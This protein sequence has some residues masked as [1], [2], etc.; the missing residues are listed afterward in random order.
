VNPKITIAVAS[1]A[2]GLAGCA[3]NRRAIQPDSGNTQITEL[4]MLDS[5]HGW[6][7]S[8]GLAGQRSLLRTDDGGT[9]WQDVTPHGFPHIEEGASFRDAHTAWVSFFNKSDVTA[10]LLRT[11]DGGKSWSLLNQT[12]TPIFNEASSCRFYSSTYGVG[13][14]SDGGAGSAY[15]IFFETRDSGKTW[16]RIPLMPRH[17]ESVNDPS[18]F[19]LSN[20]GGDRIAFC[21]PSTVIITFGDTADEQPK[22]VARLSMTTNLGKDWRDVELPLPI[23]FHNSLCVPLKPVFADKKEIILAAHVIESNV[24]SYSTGSLVFYTSRDGGA[25]WTTK[26]G[27]IELKQ[28]WHGDGFEVVS[29][30]CF[31]VASD[32]NFWVTHDGAQS[33]ES[34]TPNILFGANSKR[35]IVQMDFVDARHG[36]LVISDNNQF[37]PNGNFILYR[38]TDGGKTWT[39]LPARIL[40]KKD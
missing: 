7:W 31:L 33:W 26:P 15:V 37:H 35:D 5:H 13:D 27:T 29:P 3:T 32:S 23:Q 21:P 39:E 6:A 8:G 9:T 10:G 12:N 24:S 19:H 1:L 34:L 36:W 18:T 28:P 30:G 4:H 14:S 20:V 11:T 2:F 38:T 16:S 40:R 25:S 22:G 17:P